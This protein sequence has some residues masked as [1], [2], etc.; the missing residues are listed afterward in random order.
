MLSIFIT[1]GYF[2]DRARAGLLTQ[3]LAAFPEIAVASVLCTVSQLD[4]ELHTRSL[5]DLL[6][7]AEREQPWVKERFTAAVAWLPLQVCE[8]ALA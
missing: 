3:R 4:G 8:A 2:A 6:R 5:K 1:S 7:N